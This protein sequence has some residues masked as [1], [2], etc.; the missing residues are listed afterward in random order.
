MVMGKRE[1][2]ARLTALRR[3]CGQPSGDPRGV[4]AQSWERTRAGISPR[5]G[6]NRKLSSE[7]TLSPTAIAGLGPGRSRGYFD[8]DWPACL[9]RPEPDSLPPPLCLFTVA[10]A[11]DRKSVG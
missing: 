3:F 6:R 11:R 7:F 9:P 8:L 10:Q 5:C 1:P 4:A 2:S